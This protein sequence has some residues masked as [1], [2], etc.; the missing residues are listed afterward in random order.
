MKSN[1]AEG[2]T[3]TVAW[4]ALCVSL[5][6]C[7]A[8]MPLTT[9]RRVDYSE[10]VANVFV[11]AYPAVPWSAISEKLQPQHNLS[12][13]DAR[14]LAAVTTQ[15]QVNQFLSTFS[16]G[17]AVS[18]PLKTATTTTEVAA[19][20]TT[21]TTGSR[22]ST[23]GSVP[24]SSGAPTSTVGNEALVP[25]LS[26]GP[27]AAG[28]DASTQLIAGTGVYQ[29]AK[30]L[31]NQITNS[32]KLD[33]YEAHL[34]TLQVNL[35]P[36]GRNLPYDAYVSVTMLPG[37]WKKALETSNDVETD[38]Q[39][40]PPVIMYPLVVT[41]AMESASVGRS[42]EVIRQAALQL[43]GIVANAGVN[44]GLGGGSDR[45]ES[46]IGADR[47]SLVTLGRV[48]DHTIRIRLG[49]QSQGSRKLA[50]VPRTHNVSLVVFTRAKPSEYVDRL[51]IITETTFVDVESGVTKPSLRA[52]EKAREG[53][54]VAVQK[55]VESYGYSL[56]EGCAASDGGE[57]LALDLLRA[58]DR[59]DYRYV[60]RCLAEV[61]EKTPPRRGSVPEAKARTLF[62]L[63]LGSAASSPQGLK[64]VEPVGEARLRRLL[65]SLMKIQM[66]SR[67]SKLLVQLTPSPEPEAPP[68]QLAFLSD[69]G[70]SS[71]TLV[72]R[73]G[74]QIKAEKVV[75]RLKFTQGDKQIVLV[76]N[77]V[78][79]EAD[80]A[81]RVS[82]P[83][84]VASDLQTE[85]PVK[86]PSL[87][88][89]TKGKSKGKVDAKEEPPKTELGVPGPV[90]LELSYSPPA[91]KFKTE[92]YQVKYLKA[93]PEAPGNPISVSNAVLV[94][95]ASGT[96]K[97]T[98]MV[99]AWK[100]AALGVRISGADVRAIEPAAAF[101]T[102]R[103]AVPLTEKSVVVLTLGNLSPTQ[104][105][106]VRT[107]AGTKPV[108]NAILLAVESPRL[109]AAR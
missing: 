105:V 52:G 49:A 66:D 89:P 81:L 96:A 71:A 82:F 60:S 54:R 6:S 41:D 16:A 9:E 13:A 107:I 20:G 93:E 63:T 103:M 70:K 53:L 48:S 44:L 64:G 65:A 29:L 75:A 34:L 91:T 5:A 21:T 19:D 84:I 57:D 36:L 35:Q 87:K 38:G 58:V 47:N 73:E 18:L 42:L 37:T 26:K 67:H 68:S 76:P 10:E 11:A 2:I 99:G 30:V 3:R 4:S 28:L 46:I 85:T 61:A 94:P 55:V 33:G 74:K 8:L 39:G 92:T 102:A 78:G 40:L 56:N 31:D 22:Q 32:V 51:A 104:P 108:G 12:T 25:D 98:L 90:A 79:V 7:E 59:S 109:Q 62:E 69:D 50:L 72:L 14:A 80:G 88:E 77:S 27:L 106:Q 23:S 24:T 86:P 1:F 45:L 43:S 17:L 100:G 95:D 15:T 101:D 97:L 83:S